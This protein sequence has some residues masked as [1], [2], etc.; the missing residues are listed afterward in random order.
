VRRISAKL[1]ASTS[2]VTRLA[3]G[4]GFGLAELAD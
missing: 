2:A 4:D 1:L 3:F